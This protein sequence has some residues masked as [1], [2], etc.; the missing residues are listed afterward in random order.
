[1]PEDRRIGGVRRT[2]NPPLL[3]LH[4][5]E[6][7]TYA[8]ICPQTRGGGRHWGALVNVGVR[9]RAR[10]RAPMNYMPPYTPTRK[11]T[12]AFGNAYAVTHTPVTHKNANQNRGPHTSAANPAKATQKRPWDFCGIYERSSMW[13]GITPNSRKKNTPTK[14]NPPSIFSGWALSERW[15]GGPLMGNHLDAA[16]HTLWL[17]CVRQGHSRA[18]R[19]PPLLPLLTPHDAEPLSLTKTCGSKN[20]YLQN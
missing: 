7:R 18:R 13:H 5:T 15:D 16:P 12:I 9:Q 2:R 6:M 3:E 14:T 11:F 1:M 20:D 4:S 19:P 17:M 10:Y 8:N